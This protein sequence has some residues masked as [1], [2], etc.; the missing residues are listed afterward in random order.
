[1]KYTHKGLKE[2][3][4]SRFRSVIQADDAVQCL[5]FALYKTGT[6]RIWSNC[7]GCISTCETLCSAH[8]QG[9]AVSAA[10]PNVN[11]TCHAAWETQTAMG[12]TL[13]T[14]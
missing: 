5:G 1:M 4:Q 11:E 12:P 10:I 7:K 3:E 13:V 14:L 9:H 2:K 6:Y 8:M